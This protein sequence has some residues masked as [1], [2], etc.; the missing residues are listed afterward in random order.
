MIT[1]RETLA[2]AA[3][4][5]ALT[6]AGRAFSQTPGE[7]DIK[8]KDSAL[9][10]A[11]DVYYSFMIELSRQNGFD[12]RDKMLLGNTIT[13]FDISQDTPY[14]NEGLFRRFADRI[15]LSS[16]AVIGPANQADR[17]SLQYE[18]V[19]RTAAD[20]VDQRHPEIVPKMQ[21]LDRAIANNTKK[22]ADLIVDIEGKWSKVAAAQ[23]LKPESLNYDL[24]HLNFLEKVRYADQIDAVSG[25]IDAL[26]GRKEQ[27]RR[28]VYTPSEIILLEAVAQLSSTRKV[29][30]P[31]RPQFERTDP[32]V[33]ELTFADPKVRL[34]SICDIS[35]SAY[36]VGDL[37]KFLKFDGKRGISITKTSTAVEQHDKSWSGG[38]GGG[39]SF[40]GIG[41]SVGGGGGGSS[42]YKNAVSDIES[43]SINFDNIAEVLIDRGYWFN[44][45]IFDDAA[46]APILSKIAG[47]DRLKYVTVSLIIGRGLELAFT[48]NSS[49][50]TTAWS[51]QEVSARGGA[52][53]LG[54]SFGGRGGSSSYDYTLNVSADGKTVTFKD[55]PQLARVVGIRVTEMNRTPP[56]ADGGVEVLKEI[57]SGRVLQRP[58]G[59][60][61]SVYQEFLKGHI[62]YLEMMA[63]RLPSR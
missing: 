30:R 24:Q 12:S 11:L 40:F 56:P 27:V 35:P 3:A 6:A 44:P 15:F 43:L 23:G 21:E 29:A 19:V 38:G 55:D 26:I 14:F 2:S 50:D 9:P 60:S 61:P 41:F 59:V 20:Q 47:I 37:V 32:T 34:E 49:V 1:R 4:L 8:V 7:V 18:T 57:T 62:P 52:S 42:S 16:P 13:S 31:L 5:A 39:A 63:G 45:A 51:K 25:R 53:F 10:A 36:P 22:L 48:S 17:F 46:L 28:S 54:F 33:K 58:Q